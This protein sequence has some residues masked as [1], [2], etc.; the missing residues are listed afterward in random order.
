MSEENNKK[1]N[2]NPL[3]EQVVKEIQEIDKEFVDPY[4][5]NSKLEKAEIKKI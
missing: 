4:I 5:P 1:I 3:T 2:P